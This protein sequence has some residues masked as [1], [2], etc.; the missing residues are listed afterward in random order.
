MPGQSPA[1]TPFVGRRLF[2]PLG[3]HRVPLRAGCASRIA[4]DSS[5]GRCPA[6]RSDRASASPTQRAASSSGKRCIRPERGGHSSSNSLLRNSASVE[7]RSLRGEDGDG[8]A[9]RVAKGAQLDDTAGP[10]AGDAELFGELAQRHVEVALAGLGLAL[11]DRPGVLLLARPERAAHVTEEDLE[12][13]C[14]HPVQ[15]DPRAVSRHVSSLRRVGPGRGGVP[16]SP[17]ATNTTS[18]IRYSIAEASAALTMQR[19]VQGAEVTAGDHHRARFGPTP[20]RAGRAPSA[21]SRSSGCP[22]SPSTT[23]AITARAPSTTCVTSSATEPRPEAHVPLHDHHGP[24]RRRA[25]RRHAALA[26]GDPEGVISRPPQRETIGG[27]C[28]VRAVRERVVQ[29]RRAASGARSSRPA[30]TG[31]T[32]PTPD[33]SSCAARSATG[34]GHGPG[35]RYAS[36][37]AGRSTRIPVPAGTSRPRRG[38]YSRWTPSSGAPVESMNG[39]GTPGRQY[40]RN[41][42]GDGHVQVNTYA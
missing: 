5:A 32:A 40:S 30:P 8:L 7:V 25:Q 42:R 23:A 11:R 9:A 12:A 17:P 18:A 15:Q 10:G 21:I 29:D 31:T 13:G 38:R 22:S 1:A 24:H 14:R 6:T 19:R 37:R 41:T 20:G 4:K 39:M 27:R 36:R 26:Q 2:A 3:R 16:R 35:C 33:R 28:L 34:R